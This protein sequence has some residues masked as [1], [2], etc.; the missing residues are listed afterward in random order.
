MFQTQPK[1]NTPI[2]V[3]T[4]ED[5]TLA[6]QQA[7]I[8]LSGEYTSSQT[9][10]NSSE[11][12]PS[13]QTALQ[14]DMPRM[15]A[16]DNDLSGHI[17]SHRDTP[18]PDAVSRDLTEDV[19]THED[20][21][22]AETIT[23]PNLQ[24]QSAPKIIG[25]ENSTIDAEQNFIEDVDHSSELVENMIEQSVQYS[26]QP[27]ENA[28]PPEKAAPSEPLEVANVEAP[29]A[30]SSDKH[31]VKTNQTNHTAET[32]SA[33]SEPSNDN[34]E[35]P[36]PAEL[37]NWVD[38]DQAAALLRE[39]GISRTVRTIQ[40][41]C[42]KGDLICK[43]VPTENASRYIINE[44]SIETFVKNFSNLLP[45]ST[46]GSESNNEQS[47]NL[48]SP[49]EAS[50]TPNHHPLNQKSNTRSADPTNQS[51]HP[52]SEEPSNSAQNRNTHMEQ[53]VELKDQHIDMLQSQLSTANAQIA[54]KD[55]QIN[56]MLERDHETN[57]LIQNLQR[58]IALP[59]GRSQSTGWKQSNDAT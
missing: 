11:D 27:F 20:P 37:E 24:T 32:I 1:T 33:Q 48:I 58:L 5:Q 53:I 25:H 55:E 57:V 40:R 4:D 22:Y 17:A 56:T 41:L 18:R 49:H 23:E 45:G 34:P 12:A 26:N 9:I 14:R 50:L 43:L 29:N 31:D 54:V 59:E 38:V 51:H 16:T 15:T 7:N 19:A 44:Q 3:P 6:T 47:F 10:D 36:I 30:P 46:F 42:K 2:S 52:S 35:T 28:T 8:G 13:R 21:H 39:R